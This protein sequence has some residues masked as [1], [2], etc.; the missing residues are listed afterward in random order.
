[1][2]RQLDH[3]LPLFDTPTTPPRPEDPLL[4]A[5]LQQHIAQALSKNPTP[6]DCFHC[7]SSN[8]TLRYRGRP[9]RG[10][11]YFKCQH[12]GK[13]FNRRTGTALQSFLR[14]EK[15]DEF[16]PLL[17]Q[18]RSIASASLKLGVAPLW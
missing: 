8:V 13:G 4:T 14:A 15:L 7:N 12:C 3:A 6:P 18:Q 17:S 2:N 9:P 11:P 16:L 5:Y 10:I 1:M